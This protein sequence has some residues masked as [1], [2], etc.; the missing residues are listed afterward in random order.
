MASQPKNMSDVLVVLHALRAGAL[1]ELEALEEF[2][3][4]V[5]NRARSMVDLAIVIDAGLTAL[6][7]LADETPRAA[8]SLAAVRDRSA[9]LNFVANQVLGTS[10]ALRNHVA[11]WHI[12]RPPD[13]FRDDLN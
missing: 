1:R 11:R 12:R 4:E 13:G 9:A 8:L 6:Q 10:I 2:L 3:D 5:V 7:P